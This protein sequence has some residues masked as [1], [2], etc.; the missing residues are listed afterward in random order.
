MKYRVVFPGG[1]VFFATNHGTFIQFDRT[2][3]LIKRCG[4]ET[5]SESIRRVYPNVS[6]YPESRVWE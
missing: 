5:A 3:K 6:I 2:L 4:W 1:N